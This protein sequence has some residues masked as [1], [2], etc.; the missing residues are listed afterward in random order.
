MIDIFDIDTHANI[1][2]LE[3]LNVWEALVTYEKQEKES[4]HGQTSHGRANGLKADL[5]MRKSPFM[6]GY[7]MAERMAWRP[8]FTQ[9]RVLLWMVIT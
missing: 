9:E 1:K 6:D 8:T 4:F 3:Y 5:Y 2:N 7:Y